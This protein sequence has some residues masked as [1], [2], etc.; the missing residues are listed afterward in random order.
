MSE[1]KPCPFCGSD[2]IVIGNPYPT[3]FYTEPSG[4]PQEEKT[5]FWVRCNN[6]FAKTANYDKYETAIEAWNRRAE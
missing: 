1:L 3:Q 4:M 5:L 2:Y 6:C